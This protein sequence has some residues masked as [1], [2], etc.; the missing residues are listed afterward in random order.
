MKSEAILKVLE[1]VRPKYFLKPKVD[2]E[3]EPYAI[4]KND[5]FDLVVANAARLSGGSILSKE[6]QD[7]VK[8]II[9]QRKNRIAERIKELGLNEPVFEGES[10]RKA[11]QLVR[12]LHS[13][14]T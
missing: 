12:W 6:Q 13:D 9:N 11:Q 1:E 3:Y 5:A 7:R 14:P 8:S 10:A 2:I 4:G